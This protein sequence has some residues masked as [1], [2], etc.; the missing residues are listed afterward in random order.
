VSVTSIA[1]TIN[2]VKVKVSS[3][4]I[5]TGETAGHEVWECQIE[6]GKRLAKPPGSDFRGY[7][8]GFDVEAHTTM[9][10]RF[11]PIRNRKAVY[12]NAL[13]G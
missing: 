13:F 3:V 4:R 8:T 7:V 5:G 9:P 10:Y 11:D 2:R 12:W 1:P 6:L